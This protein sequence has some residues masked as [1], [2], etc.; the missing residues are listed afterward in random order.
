MSRIFKASRLLNPRTALHMGIYYS[1]NSLRKRNI[2]VRP[3]YMAH[4]K[5]EKPEKND[6]KFWVL[7]FEPE[8]LDCQNRTRPRIYSGFDGKL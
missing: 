8:T 6:L 3:W 7:S 1:A 5:P 4:V 2:A